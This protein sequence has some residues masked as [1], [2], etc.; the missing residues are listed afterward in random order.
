MFVF[1][2]VYVL[3]WTFLDTYAKGISPMDATPIQ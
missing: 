2:E 3:K 1:F